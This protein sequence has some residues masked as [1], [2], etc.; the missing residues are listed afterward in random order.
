MPYDFQ[1]IGTTEKTHFDVCTIWAGVA[2]TTLACQL[3][4]AGT[5]AGLLEIGGLTAYPAV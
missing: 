1:D 3:D 5:S 4:R 2:G